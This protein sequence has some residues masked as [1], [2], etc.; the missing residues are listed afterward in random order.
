MWLR[1]STAFSPQ[2]TAITIITAMKHT[3]QF[4]FLAFVV[5]LSSC[6]STYTTTYYIVRHAEKADSTRD[7]QLSAEG[8]ARAEALRDILMSENIT[9]I[10]VTNYQR[11]QQTAEPLA[12][13]LGITSTE[14]FANQTAEL[15]QQL[16]AINGGNILI[17]GHS[18]TVP[19]IIN[20]LMENPQN[21]LITEKDFN[22]LFKVKIIKNGSEAVREFTQLTYGVPTR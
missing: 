14:V 22:D 13:S 17:V 5:M 9:K 8:H 7:T 6:T 4:L 2:S 3:L 21:V 12:T 19:V 15:V 1:T 11:T 16:K 20:E 10:F 18:N